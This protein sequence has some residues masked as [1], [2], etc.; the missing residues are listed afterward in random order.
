VA[1]GTVTRL[2]ESRGLIGR[3]AATLIVQRNG[4][5]AKVL[6]ELATPKV[7]PRAGGHDSG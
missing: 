5:S 3:R 1:T 6:T 2:L 4:E 7:L